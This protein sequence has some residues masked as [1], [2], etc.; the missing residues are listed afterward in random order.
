MKM[1]LKN[2]T[3]RFLYEVEYSELWSVF[4]DIEIHIVLTHANKSFY[5]EV[6]FK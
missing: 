3:I 6:Y 5:F 4:L 1:K 2:P